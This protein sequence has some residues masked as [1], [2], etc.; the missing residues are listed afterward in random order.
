MP[1]PPPA[2]PP[3]VVFTRDGDWL[4][5]QARG[6]CDLAWL[7]ALIP[8]VVA[9]H[10]RAP[11]AAVLVDA[12]ALRARM[13]DLDRHELGVSM[14]QAR[15]LP[16]IAFVA[17]ME[18]LDPRRIGELAARNRGANVRVFTDIAAAREWLTAAS[19]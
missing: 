3:E 10:D 14:A 13:G 18:M 1:T 7:K 12:R 16:P 2:T 15:Q 17:S 8:K 5:V 6:E 11:A 9:E 4:I 19:G